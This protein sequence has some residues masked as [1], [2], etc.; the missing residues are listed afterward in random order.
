[1]KQNVSFICKK[2]IWNVFSFNT[3]GIMIWLYKNEY[4]DCS[5][6]Y[7]GLSSSKTDLLRFYKVMKWRKMAANTLSDEK[8]C[9]TFNFM[10]YSLFNII[11][12]INLHIF[13]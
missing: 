9:Q 7:I 2:K 5:L 13:I 12:N 8:K 4:V 3:R 6:K 1:M 11:N 10:K